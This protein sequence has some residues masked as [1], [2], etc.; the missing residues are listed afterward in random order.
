M[1]PFVFVLSVEWPRPSD[2]WA[3]RRYGGPKGCFGHGFNSCIYWCSPV[4]IALLMNR[5]GSATISDQETPAHNGLIAMSPSQ[6]RC[7]ACDDFEARNPGRDHRG[8]ARPSSIMVAPRRSN[9]LLGSRPVRA[10]QTVDV[11]VVSLPTTHTI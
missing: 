1:N 6:P 5:S 11:E 7:A 8:P 10:Q 3:R 4:P 9:R 2:I